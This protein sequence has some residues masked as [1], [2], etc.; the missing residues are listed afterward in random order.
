M[1]F[2]RRAVFPFA[3]LL[4]A[5]VGARGALAAGPQAVDFNDDV[6]PILNTHCIACHGGVKQASGVSFIRRDSALA[7]AESGEIPIVPGNVDASYLMT[8][9]TAGDDERMPPADHGRA[10]S[11]GEI[12]TLRRWIEQGAEWK[13]HWAYVPPVSPAMPR[14]ERRDW[15]AGPLDQ[16]VLASLAAAELEPSPP[17]DRRAWLRRATFDLTGLPPTLDEQQSFL[18]DASALARERVVD[19]L[20]ASPAFGERWASVWLDLARYADTMGYER[21]PP[22]TIWPYRDWLVRA[23]N[24]D[25]P[26]DQFTIKQLAGDLLEA[27]AI[28]DLIATA[29]HRNTQTNTEGGTDDEEFRT[30][31][32]V[33]RVN[34]TWQVWQATTFGCTQCHA[35]PYAPFDHDEYYKF[36]ALFNT[37]SD[38]DLREEFPLVDVPL[39][40]TAWNDARDLDQQIGALRAAQFAEFQ[41]VQQSAEAFVALA[42]DR[43]ECNGSARLEIR[44]VE[45]GGAEVVTVGTDSAHST[46]TLESPVPDGLARLTALRIEALPKDIEAAV[47]T[48]EPGFVLSRLQ[49][50]VVG[51]DGEPRE[52]EFATA[53]AD[54]PAP[55]FDPAD[56][57]RENANGWA[58]YTRISAPRAGVFIAARPVELAPGDRLRFVLLQDRIVEDAIPMVLRRLRLAASASD[59]WPRLIASRGFERRREQLAKLE[60][61][62]GEMQHVSLPVMREAP[63][64]VARRTFVFDR[65]NW[66]VKGQEV[67][68]AVP[69]VFPQPA[70]EI[71]DRL[72]LARWIVSPENPLAARVMVNR[73]WAEL[74]GTGIVETAEDFGS[75]GAPPSHPELLD[76]LAVRFRDDYAWS[77]KRLLREIVLSSTYGQDARAEAAMWERDPRNRLLARGPRNRLSAE[78]V[79]DQ[80]LAVSGLASANLYGPPVMPPQPEGVWRSVYNGGAWEAARGDNRYRRA[81]Y[82]YWKRTSGYPA[83]MTFDAPSRE[84][85]SVRRIATNTPLQALAALNDEAQIECAQALGQRMHDAGLASVRDEIAWAYELASGAKPTERAIEPLVKLYETALAAYQSDPDQVSRMSG[86][87]EIAARAVVANAI[88]N[89]DV[90]LTK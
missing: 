34:T 39:D 45:E 60:K 89:L 71:L 87:A 16:L 30:M 8:R 72:A 53:L 58:S 2:A 36:M 14:V 43:A 70:S 67:A 13:E 68:P 20:L 75:S 66:L 57:L 65:G 78:M 31:A 50:Y 33:D 74:F 35:H 86:S 18:A 84:T 7:E 6:R 4:C 37:S 69:H 3:I 29:F 79:R 44:A 56:S 90:V 81:L 76:D 47:R 62:R 48:S 77:V 63:D 55:E 10:L 25:L 40:E 41:S 59:A 80:A 24:A 17:A 83:M 11:E 38:C 19:R 21:D 32:V 15:C 12:N 23:L 22:R 46:Y 54:E 61:H 27:P 64:A 73:L 49:V 26:F 88:L 51:A 85:C 82:T 28:D 9:V 42:P 1:L 5:V 52:I